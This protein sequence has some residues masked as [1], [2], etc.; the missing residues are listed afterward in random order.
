MKKLGCP[1]AKVVLMKKF[2]FVLLENKIYYLRKLTV[3]ILTFILVLF[4]VYWAIFSNQPLVYTGMSLSTLLFHLS[5]IIFDTFT[6][7]DGNLSGMNLLSTVCVSK[8][9]YCTAKSFTIKLTYFRYYMILW[10]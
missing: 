5:G 8:C 2:L 9:K 7:G 1:R 6:F 4:K 10:S 3:K